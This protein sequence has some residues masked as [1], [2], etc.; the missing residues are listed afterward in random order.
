MTCKA[1]QF[2]EIFHIIKSSNNHRLFCFFFFFWRRSHTLPRLLGGRGGRD[3]ALQV[4]RDRG[5][6]ASWIWA[7][8]K[9]TTARCRRTKNLESTTTGRPLRRLLLHCWHSRHHT[10]IVPRGSVLR[11]RRNWT[12]PCDLLEDEGKENIHL[13][14]RW[15]GTTR[16]G[17]KSRWRT[18]KTPLP[19]A[20]TH[21]RTRIKWILIPSR[22]DCNHRHPPIQRGRGIRG[23]GSR[24]EGEGDGAE[25]AKM[26]SSYLGVRKKYCRRGPVFW[27]SGSGLWRV[28]V[29][30]IWNQRTLLLERIAEKWGIPWSCVCQLI[31]EPPPPLAGEF[32]GWD[33]VTGRRVRRGGEWVVDTEA[34]A[35]TKDTG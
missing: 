28:I 25:E 32:A 17:V 23:G 10:N 2:P 18:A 34:W 21:M 30:S 1:P 6:P 13:L 11:L 20:E 31:R 27:I 35:L 24:G 7:V 16:F 3:E 8:D 15:I 5:S 4:G 26:T 29:L 9:R 12:K 14:V 19:D 33:M 22:R